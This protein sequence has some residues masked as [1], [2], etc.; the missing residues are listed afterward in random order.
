[1]KALRQDK[2]VFI[3]SAIMICLCAI[4]IGIPFSITIIE[5]AA[6]T[7]I[8]L[9]LF[10]KMFI[11]RSV[12]IKNTP[13]NWPLAVYLLFVI[14]SLI[15]SQF[16]TTSVRGLIR[17]IL[18]YIA[19]YFVI[20]E[21]VKTD[22]DVK[23]LVGT[24]LV[25]CTLI[26][27][28]GVWQYFSGQDFIRAYPIWSMSRMKASFKFPTGFGGWLI[29]VLPLCISLAIFNTKEK[30][31]KGWG[32]FLS[33]LLLSCLVLSLTRGAWLAFIPAIIFL[34]WKR[35]DAAKVILL[36]LLVALILL[37]GSM[38]LLGGGEKL[39]LY[40][41]R[42]PAVVHRI[43]LTKLA[44]RMFI[45]RPY[46][47]HGINTFMSIYERYASAFDYSGISYAHNCYLQMA[48]E[49]G[50]FGLLAFLW[51][52]AALFT[53]S[54]KDINKRKDGLIKAAEIGLLGGLLAYLAHSALETNL[55]ALQL[56]VLFHFMLGLT[57]SV[58][59][60]KEK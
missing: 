45:E 18:E 3:D 48:V 16:L 47:G 40:T 51:M 57:V 7:A 26:G 13:L 9:W 60:V 6:T 39:A 2:G 35:G 59:N 10:K 23:R 37:I 50:V 31:Y 1:M 27:I 24:I 25:S 30:R 22:R 4:I 44:W 20:V 21:T 42:A 56:A 19:I 28:D 58:Q 32:I 34:V 41:I 5:I 12:R 33:V 46:V 52:I 54:L 55:Y 29:T 36:L 38:M 14:L 17:K 53:S 11:E 15:N 8:L 49:T 43:D